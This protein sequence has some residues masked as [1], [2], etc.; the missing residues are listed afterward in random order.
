MP[1]IVKATRINQVFARID[2]EQ[3][4]ARE[5]TQKFKFQ[6]PGY[7]FTP[8]FKS[9]FWDGYIYLFS[10]KTQLIYNGLLHYVEA[11]CK[12]N[13]FEFVDTS[14]EGAAF[15]WD[16]T[17]LKEWIATLG[18]PAR[19]ESRD[20][21]TDTVLHCIN[22]ER[23]LFVSPTGSGKSLMMYQLARFHE[24]LGPILIIVPNIG[25][26]NQMTN[27]FADYGY[28]RTN[29]HRIF[30]NQSKDSSSQIVI[31][32]WQSIY[33]LP[34]E[35]FQKFACVIGDEAHKAKAQELK[36]I[37]EKM[38]KTRYR[39]GMTGSLDGTQTNQMVLEGLFGPHKKVVTTSE[40]IERGV[41]A[42]LKIRVMLL[43]HKPDTCREV[44]AM[45]DYQ[46]ERAKIVA[47]DARNEFLCN[48]AMSLEGNVL[49]LYQLVDAH[50]KVLYDILQSKV[51]KSDHKIDVNLIHGKV[52]AEEREAIRVGVNDKYR[53]ITVAS[54]GCFAEGINIPNLDYLILASPT[55]S[56]VRVMQM[57][58]R[59]LR[60]TERKNKCV[61]FD[62]ADD[63]SSGKYQNFTLRHYK[64]RLRYY[65]EENF[66]YSQYKVEL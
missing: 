43:K 8:R 21:Q 52:E 58:G 51:A 11:Y 45:N 44:K 6:V 9:G 41:L 14:R 66:N 36:G 47:C 55:K 7:Q 50:G 25:L 4:V 37:L 17:R 12:E 1:T 33:K 10:P 54:M 22:N 59:V 13:G 32:T 63:L 60:K 61:V 53:S 40:L 56:R 38:T 48:L 3:F 42:D 31:S 23:A 57:I 19:F 46:F 29:I 30:A 64:E 35:W 15:P 27:D 20:Y 2:C 18:I 26:V 5:L 65:S 62:L 16:E 28:D 39:F 24:N 34:K 49:V